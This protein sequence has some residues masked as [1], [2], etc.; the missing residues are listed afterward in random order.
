MSIESK[1]AVVVGARKD[2]ESL[3]R[4]CAYAG[5]TNCPSLVPVRGRNERIE[6]FPQV[7]DGEERDNGTIKVNGCK[8]VLKRLTKKINN[9]K[10]KW[11]WN[12][13]T[14]RWELIE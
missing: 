10:P 1:K 3:C 7:T 14:H 5:C 6:D 4:T 11:D 12:I 13:Y 2:M 8:R 9:G